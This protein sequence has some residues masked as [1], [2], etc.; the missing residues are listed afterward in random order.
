MNSEIEGSILKNYTDKFTAFMIGAIVV[1]GSAIG[2]AKPASAGCTVEPYLAD[3][4]MTAAPH[5]PPKYTKADG[6]L[7]NMAENMILFSVLSNK[8]G[9]D[10]V[11]EFALP[12]L[13]K[14]DGEKNLILYCIAVEGPIAPQR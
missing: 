13:N 8:F 4:C 14:T 11:R 2:G 7:L 10:G 1:A 5:C 9:G 6:Q 3:I 12:K